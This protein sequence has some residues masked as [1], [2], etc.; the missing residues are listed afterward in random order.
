MNYSL[1]LE[2]K[3]K[4]FPQ[5]EELFCKCAFQ[6]VEERNK[7]PVVWDC[8]T[9][10]VSKPTLEELIEEC[11]KLSE[12]GDFHLERNSFE[13]QFQN[14]GASVDC[15]KNEPYFDGKTPEEAIANLWLALQDKK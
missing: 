4:G 9:E 13:G 12:T 15:F 7:T 3:N 6:S 8:R 2:L 5:I 14:W 11:V 10:L 1:A